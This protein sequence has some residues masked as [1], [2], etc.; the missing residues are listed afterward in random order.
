MDNLPQGRG[1]S[2]QP[3]PS[4]QTGGDTMTTKPKD[5]QSPMS[6]AFAQAIARHKAAQAHIDAH[7]G[8]IDDEAQ[9][10]QLFAAESDALEALAETPC[11]DA[12][13]GEKLRYLLAHEA[14]IVD[15]PPDGH[16]NPMFRLVPHRFGK[17]NIVPAFEKQFGPIREVRFKF[18]P[19]GTCSA[20]KF[21]CVIA[22]SGI[23]GSLVMPRTVKI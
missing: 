14:R 1:I 21:G 4:G 18:N 2:I 22:Q 13:F 8:S 3:A 10:N 16:Q 7:F 20:V 9:A 23:V 15:G 11:S 12:E 5:T 19:D 17:Q 6:G